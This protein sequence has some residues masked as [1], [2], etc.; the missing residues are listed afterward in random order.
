[1]NSEDFINEINSD[2][3]KIKS[4]TEQVSSEIFALTS[5]YCMSDENLYYVLINCRKAN[6]HLYGSLSIAQNN[7]VANTIYLKTGPY[8]QYYGQN[9]QQNPYPTE[10]QCYQPNPSFDKPIIFSRQRSSS[11]QSHLRD[12]WEDIEPTPLNEFS[13]SVPNS[14]TDCH[15][16]HSEIPDPVDKPMDINEISNVEKVNATKPKAFAD[17][18]K[19]TAENNDKNTNELKKSDQKKLEPVVKKAI[20]PFIKQNETG[21]W[22]L[23]TKPGM[24]LGYIHN[25]IDELQFEITNIDELMNIKFYFRDADEINMHGLWQYN[26]KYFLSEDGRVFIYTKKRE[27]VQLRQGGKDIT[28][29]LA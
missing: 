20:K 8:Q 10:P 11:S 3:N 9:F 2:F 14:V 23:Q 16:D 19:Q 12:R 21:I 25:N 27:L 24:V 28:F 18:V 13:M 5:K 1:M 15:H 17:V 4:L 6:E 29:K 22:N 26:R 7:N